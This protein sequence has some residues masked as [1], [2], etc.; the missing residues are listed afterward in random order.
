MAFKD[1]LS[2]CGRIG[3]IVMAFAFVAGII[4]GP[5]LERIWSSRL[6]VTQNNETPP[7]VPPKS[8]ATPKTAEPG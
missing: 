8:P 5:V 7:P 2:L 1:M 6:T 3:L 4:A